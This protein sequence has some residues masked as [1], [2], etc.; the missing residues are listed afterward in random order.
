MAEQI[1]HNVVNNS[2]SASGSPFADVA[3]NPNSVLAA[4][5]GNS[6]SI[7]VDSN[8]SQSSTHLGKTTNSDVGEPSAGNDAYAGSLEPPS[9]LHDVAMQG[10]AN[11]I[12][13]DAS[14]GEG[15]A[16]DRSLAEGSIDAS[17]NSDTDTSR[18]DIQ[19]QKDASSHNRTNSMKK[20]ATFSKVSVTRNF[21][22]K[23]ATAP[24]G[25]TSVKPGEKG[26]GPCNEY[27]FGK[28]LT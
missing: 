9:A 10:R 3:V 14:Q 22:A 5:D 16:D 2:Q 15:V 11:D 21:L 17:A 26:Q 28:A 19:E 7:N 20:P 27:I 1:G 12:H 24:T 23:T 25:A 4:S 13:D 8:T 18:A 6:P